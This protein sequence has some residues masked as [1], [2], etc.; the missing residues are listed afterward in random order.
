MSSKAVNSIADL[1][2]R[3][4]SLQIG[5]DPGQA[6]NLN[7]HLAQVDTSSSGRFVLIL[8]PVSSDHSVVLPPESFTRLRV[9]FSLLEYSV[10]QQRE[11]MS[12]SP[13]SAISS[14]PSLHIGLCEWNSCA[15][16]RNT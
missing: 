11:S 7:D 9:L 10:E 12:P 6:L 16:A 2:Q 14:L 13:R 8:D 3:K 4:L 15:C 5:F 1:I